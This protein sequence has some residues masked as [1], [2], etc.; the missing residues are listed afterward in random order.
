VESTDPYINRVH[1]VIDPEA[2]FSDEETRQLLAR[3]ANRQEE[4]DRALPGRHGGSVHT[5]AVVRAAAENVG[6]DPLHVEAA[7]K[8][9][10]L[11]RGAAPVRTR[12]GLPMELR[13]QRVLPGPVSDA[14]WERMV[15]EF[16]KEFRKSGSTSQFGPVREWIS[17]NEASSM[18]I[19]VRV[20]PVEE[21]TLLTLHQ[22][23]K[24]MSDLVY[25]VGGTFS[26]V[27]AT[28]GVI[29]ALTQTVSV[30]LPVFLLAGGLIASAMVWGGYRAWM[31][32]QEKQ[33]R[34]VL[35]RSELI[36]RSG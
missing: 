31:P 34:A 3:A 21:G 10:L 24:T 29:A 5:L 19:T 15:A 7:A 33:F 30:A 11:R 18:P 17:G 1:L 27:A 2:R 13:L 6:I 23:T 9:I 35:D 8:E 20:E 26:G 32:R 14:Q 22:E 4:A 36:A 25:V 28:F 16:R 12:A